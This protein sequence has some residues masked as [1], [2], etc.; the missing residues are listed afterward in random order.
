MASRVIGI[1][2]SPRKGSNTDT[3]VQAV[4]D[5]AKAAGAQTVKYHLNDL[6]FVGCQACFYC[7][8]NKECRIDDDAKRIIEEITSAQAVVFG[9]PIYFRQLTGQ[10]VL[11]MD[12]MYSLM[13]PELG[14]IQWAGGTKA[15]LVTSQ[16]AS[17]QSMSEAAAEQFNGAMKF[18]GFSTVDPIIH[19]NSYANIA[20]E[21]AALTRKAMEK[22]KALAA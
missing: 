9:S 3:L 21:N 4:L 15:L 5:G 8:K 7:K 22:G 1:V 14:K 12:R 18:L 2:G 16:G 17:D 6:Q 10:L 13:A 11:F 19:T 20:K